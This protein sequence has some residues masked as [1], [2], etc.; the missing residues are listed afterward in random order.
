MPLVAMDAAV[1]GLIEIENDFSGEVIPIADIVDRVNAE[2]GSEVYAYVDPGQEFVG[3]D[4]ISN[5]LIYKVDEV[6]LQGD[7]AILAEF[8]G[9]DFLDPLDAGRGSQPSCGGPD[10]R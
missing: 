1:V 5:G 6:G 9:R 2:L 8:E 7:M 4:A 3:G 10:L